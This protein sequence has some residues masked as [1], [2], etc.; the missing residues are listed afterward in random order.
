MTKIANQNLK[1]FSCILSLCILMV[2]VNG[3]LPKG[4]TATSNDL[5]RLHVEEN[6]IVNE[7]G[8]EQI[9]RGVA[10]IDPFFMEEVYKTGPSEEDFRV[11]AEEWSVD[12]VRVPIHPDLWQKSEN[13]LENYVDPIVTYGN[14]YEF[15]T[16]LGYHAHG[17][18]I[19]GEVE[20]P[21]WGNDWPWEGNPYNPDLDIA[22]EALTKMVKRYQDNPGVL[23]GT[24][25][26][27]SH[28]S[29]RKWRPIAERLVDVIHEVEPKALVFVSGVNWGYDLS[30][31]LGDPVE[32]PNVVYETHPYPW[33]RG[34]WKEV[35]RKLSK[36]FP[37]F[38][39][40]WGFN[41]PENKGYGKSLVDFAEG[42]G[43][44]WTAWVW[45]DKWTPSMYTNS[46][47]LTEFGAL[48]KE[49]LSQGGEYS[50][51]S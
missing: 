32:R 26:E 46:G 30:Q 3:Y 20:K 35:V 24:F 27:P 34:S 51:S 49:T 14:K 23:Y 44:G 1:R 21:G 13:Y 28:I 45:H 22:I 17:N 5:P 7:A 37:V 38:I 4:D 19:T 39:G 33:K 15:Y 29:W 36:H 10:V 41:S 31:V 9:L 47:L 6:N 42:I 11:L 40:E 18:P 8:E 2:C 48:V 25:N 16:F 50:G 12:I 43:L